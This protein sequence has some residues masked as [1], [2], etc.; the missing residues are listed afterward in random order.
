MQSSPRLRGDT[1]AFDWYRRVA[2]QG[3]ANAQ[4][5]LGLMYEN[6][7]GVRK[8]DAEAVSGYRLAAE[9]GIASSLFRLGLMYDSGGGVDHDPI[10]A[11]ALFGLAAAAGET[12]AQT[13]LDQGAKLTAPADIEKAAKLKAATSQPGKLL[14]ALDHYE[15]TAQRDDG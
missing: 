13:Y 10:A 15:E 4:N 14:D 9:Q 3:N 5:N 2:E 7:Q 12:R 8:D 1:D 6:G 11:N